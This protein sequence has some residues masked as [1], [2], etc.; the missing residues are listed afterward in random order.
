M[1]RTWFV[2]VLLCC[3]ALMADFK[4]DTVFGSNMVLQREVPIRFW[5]T[6]KPGSEIKV[7]FM[8]KTASATVGADS[9]WQV[10]FPAA[11]ADHVNY[12]ATFTD[13]S[14]KVEL[15]DILLGDVWFCSG[16]S[17]MEMPIGAK[18]RYG[19]SAQNCEAEVA[20]STHPELRY[21]AQKK[22]MSHDRRLP[23][24]APKGWVKSGPSESAVFS[25]TA[26][27]FGRK[28][29]EDVKVPIGLIASSW[30]GTRIQPWISKEGYEKANIA[31][32]LSLVK[33]FEL[34][35]AELKKF[36]AAEAARFKEQTAAWYESLYAAHPELKV[37]KQEWTAK[38]LDVAEWSKKALGFF[39][40][41]FTVRW[42]RVTFKV[43]EQ[44]KQE[45]MLF[46]REPGARA[47]VWLNGTRVGG[48]DSAKDNAHVR[49][50]FVELPATLLDAAGDNVLV[51]R[52]EL[53][54][55]ANYASRVCVQNFSVLRNRKGNISV[56]LKGWV[57]KDETRLKIKDAKIAAYPKFPDVQ[58]KQT[59]FP[60]HLY[61]GMVDAWTR[62]PI[63]GVIWYQGCSN[64]G[65]LRY[66][67]VHK[68]LIEDWRA[69]WNQPELPFIITQ[70]AGFGAGLTKPWSAYNPTDEPRYAITRDIQQRVADEMPNVGLACIVDIGENTN[71][72]P[73][74]K[75]D[76]GLRL[77][78]EAERIAYGMNAPQEPC[79]DKVVPEGAAIR[80]VLKHAEGLK[81][82]NG[83]APAGFAVAGEDRKFVWADAKI[84][85]NSVI[86]NST[87]VPEPKYVRYAYINF[88]ADLNL[89]NG[90]GLPLRPF[91]SDVKDLSKVK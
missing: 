40:D 89:Q 75:Q 6:G 85:G 83:K 29:L 68:A 52:A 86:V 49:H 87:K 28:L 21:V 54:G 41:S 12:T 60:T 4:L 77:A 19:W 26:Y 57:V 55:S 81:T 23:A 63:K 7:D 33:K 3:A 62:L 20:N 1:K 30:G 84:D 27:F 13:G 79:F 78:Y 37:I 66:Y 70:L 39:G 35:P 42:H 17:N 25:A 9:K 2:F 73:A 22:I 88:H 64:A 56:P 45:V 53:M 59:Q 38:E 91:R 67:P 44:L 65:D 16:Q 43:P 14:K 48:Y 11:K 24:N 50:V 72:H 51:V 32:E 34:P 5:G 10:E 15:T 80:V 69:K 36:D 76:V 74:N 46:I 61:N 8:G 31:T 90:S 82:T 71:I 58:Y 18:K 47:D